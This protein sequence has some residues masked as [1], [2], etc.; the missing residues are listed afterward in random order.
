MPVSRRSP[1]PEVSNDNYAAHASLSKFVKGCP[2][3]RFMPT[4]VMIDIGTLMMRVRAAAMR[5]VI[6]LTLAIAIRRVWMLKCHS[7]QVDQGDGFDR[8]IFCP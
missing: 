5:S 6:G 2:I 7:S 4:V 1:K 8:S 3:E